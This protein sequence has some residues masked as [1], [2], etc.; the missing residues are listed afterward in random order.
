MAAFRIN[1]TCHVRPR[2]GVFMCVL[3]PPPLGAGDR[4]AVVGVDS[5][6]FRSKI[7][8]RNRR[9]NYGSISD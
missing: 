6:R 7:K 8:T 3:C 2:R 4:E 9:K 1:R 5:P